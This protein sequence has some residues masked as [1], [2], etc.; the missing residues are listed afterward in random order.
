MNTLKTKTLMRLIFV[1]CI[2]FSHSCRSNDVAVDPIDINTTQ[3]DFEILQTQPLAT[4]LYRNPARF[5]IT[6]MA[7]SGAWIPTNRDYELGTSSQWYVELQSFGANA[8]I[9]GLIMKID[10]V[11]DAGFKAFDW[12]FAQQISDG[13]FSGTGD[14]FHSTSFFIEAVAHS[15]V[16][17]QQSPF[18]QQSL[19]LEQLYR[20]KLQKAATWLTQPAVLLSGKRRNQPYTHRYYLLAAALGVTG[21]LAGDPALIQASESFIEEGL[22]LQSSD[23]YNPELNGYDVSY[24]MV[25]LVF[26]ERWLKAFP[27]HPLA[28]KVSNMIEKGLEWE[29]AK[30]KPTGEIDTTGSTRIGKEIGRNGGTV[31]TV[32]FSAVV[33]AFGFWGIWTNNNR[34][35]EAAQKVANFYKML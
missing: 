10:S 22:A 25:G 8:V 21:K 18:S 3:T 5:Y 4:A 13:S 7:P 11:R 17:V 32:A 30:V 12:G 23:G 31:K 6:A 14:A 27:T 29:A 15:L 20:P 2:P 1:I 9:G 34:W 33:E 35:K 16:I 28:S 19:S 26:A 24:H